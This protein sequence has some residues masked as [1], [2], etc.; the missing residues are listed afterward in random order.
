MCGRV[1]V[2]TDIHSYVHLVRCRCAQELISSC[3]TQVGLAHI[4]VHNA[5]L[6]RAHSM[7]PLAYIS[8]LW[9]MPG[10]VQSRRRAEALTFLKYCFPES[11]A[12][13]VSVRSPREIHG[14]TYIDMLY[15][16]TYTSRLS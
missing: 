5:G 3:C 10:T 8:G 9:G 11:F 14:I 13:G 4:E 15:I 6:G 7:P 12:E 16:E 2:Y 1:C